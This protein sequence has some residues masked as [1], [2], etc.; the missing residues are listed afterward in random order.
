MLL[1]RPV[2]D[3]QL[4]HR[5]DARP[6]NLRGGRRDR[7]QGLGRLRIAGVALSVDNVAFPLAT[8]SRIYVTQA[9]IDRRFGADSDPGV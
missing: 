2:R 1:P 5:L 7:R 6:R 9:E 8:V 4:G 3:H